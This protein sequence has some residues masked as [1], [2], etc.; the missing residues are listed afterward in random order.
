MGNLQALID[1]LSAH[2]QQERAEKQLTL[3][4][5]IETLAA[6]PEGTEIEGLGD[7]RSYRGYYCDLAFEPEPGKR[8]VAEILEVCRS[9]MG[10]VFVGYKGGEYVMGAKTPLWLA[11][12]GSSGVEIMGIRSDGTVET[13]AEHHD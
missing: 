5:L 6:M 4:E 10:R 13:A 1:G 11:P 7:L 3:G 2:W 8:P 12:Y 9:A